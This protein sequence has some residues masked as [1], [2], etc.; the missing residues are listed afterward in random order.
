MDK[1]KMFLGAACSAFFSFFGLLAIP[2]L[3]LIGCN[4]ID[5]FTGLGA[6]YS[7]GN[8]ITSQKSFL[9]IV[10]KV[11]MYVL[12]FVGYAGD[13]LVVYISTNMNL[14]INIP[15]VI[16][17]FVAVWLVLNELISITENCEDIGV[18]IPFLAPII[19]L[20]KG[21][22]EDTIQTEESEEK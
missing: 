15:P 13:V 9:G 5:W 22:V 21:K 18:T 11:S 1:V 10:K 8:K 7:K 2:I 16:S 20:I 19:K 12:I 3:L 17:C 6:S 14:G 4:L